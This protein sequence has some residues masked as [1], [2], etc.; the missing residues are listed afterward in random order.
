MP[1]VLPDEK[2]TAGA[3][4]AAAETTRRSSG[5]KAAVRMRHQGASRRSPCRR[6]Q[7]DGGRCSSRSERW[8]TLRG[9]TASAGRLPNCAGS[10]GWQALVLSAEPGAGSAVLPG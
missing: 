5:C 9:Q 6:Q 2:I 4:P 1:G 10:F 3:E 7:R 8:F